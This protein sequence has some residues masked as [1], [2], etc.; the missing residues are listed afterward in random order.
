MEI[1][2]E[3]ERSHLLKGLTYLDKRLELNGTDK[4]YLINLQ[5]GYNGERLFDEIVN[6]VLDKEVIVLNDLLLV[7][8]GTTFQVDSI[9]IT[10]HTLYIF[11]IKNYSGKYIRNSDGLSTIQGQDVA[12]PLIQLSRMES[13]INQLLKDWSSTSKVEANV[14]FINPTFSLY[15]AKVDDP[16]L[17]PNQIESYLEDLNSRSRLLSKEQ[18][19]L[20][21]RFRKLE[22]KDAP[23][24]KQLPYY[25]YDEL[26]KGLSCKNCGSF[27][28]LI[29]QRSCCCKAC[30]FKSSVAEVILENIEEMQFLFPELKMTTTTVNEW[31][32]DIIH[33]R[34]IRKILKDNYIATGTTSG[35]IYE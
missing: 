12:N 26:K 1:L 6:K 10:S 29:T 30:F 4:R 24:Q 21:N 14:M 23:M 5:K 11:E 9:I 22:K 7:S 16:I 35:R 25:S 3:R 19:Y 8:K 28:L 15:N 33:F 2:K 18:H 27:D 31:C 34:K 13:F 17:L 32:G 20:A